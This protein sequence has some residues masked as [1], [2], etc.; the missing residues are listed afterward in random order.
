MIF[1]RQALRAVAGGTVAASTANMAAL[2]DEAS[3]LTG[4]A[5]PADRS[6]CD[7][8]ALDMQAH[9]YAMEAGE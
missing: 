8:A 1:L 2:L 9:I 5:Y 6:G 7:L 3:L 4:A